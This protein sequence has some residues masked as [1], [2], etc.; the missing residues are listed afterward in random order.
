MFDVFI[1]AYGERLEE[2]V[3][4]YVLEIFSCVFVFYI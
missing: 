3:K 2:V 4:S 1:Q